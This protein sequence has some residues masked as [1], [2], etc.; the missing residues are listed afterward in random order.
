MTYLDGY[1]ITGSSDSTVKVWTV[2]PKDQA[3]TLIIFLRRPFLL[4]RPQGRV[5]EK[6]MITFGPRYPLAVQITRLPR[7]NGLFPIPM[8]CAPN[9]Y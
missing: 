8:R 9:N 1:L 2:D 3:G 6:Q 4:N 7:S 5:R